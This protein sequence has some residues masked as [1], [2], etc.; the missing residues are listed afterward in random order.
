MSLNI[1]VANAAF[2]A[3][4]KH[5]KQRRKNKSGDPYINH[6]LEAADLIAKHVDNIGDIRKNNAMCAAI[7]HDTIEDTDT[8]YEEL[9][10][11]F[12]KDIADIVAEVTDDKKMGKVA[13]K[14]F[15][16]EHAKNISYEA[17]IVKIAD[18][19]SNLSSLRTDSPIGWKNII[20]DG[21][22]IWAAAVC[23]NLLDPECKFISMDELHNNAS[24]NLEKMLVR[25]FVTM[26]ID[27]YADNTNNLDYYYFM[28]DENEQ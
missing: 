18:K 12:G 24:N 13:R 17:K 7:L 19:Y 9:C 4:Q 23:K 5:S 1:Q 20:V 3:A 27:F 8:S 26:K 2:F 6:P 15:Q 10:N 21:Y 16:I 28:I 22:C 14:K 11:I 25:L